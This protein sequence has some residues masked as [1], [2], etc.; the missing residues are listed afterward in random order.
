MAWVKAEWGIGVHRDLRV[1]F[2]LRRLVLATFVRA[3]GVSFDLGYGEAVA[4]WARADAAS[5]R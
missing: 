3:V 1:W 2:E 5:R 4:V